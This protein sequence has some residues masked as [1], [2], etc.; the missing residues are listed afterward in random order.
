MRMKP[1]PGLGLLLV[2]A[3]GAVLFYIFAWSTLSGGPFKDGSAEWWQA[4]LGTM[5]RPNDAGPVTVAACV[6]LTLGA[7]FCIHGVW[8]IVRGDGGSMDTTPDQ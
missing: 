4:V 8:S 7:W 1:R 5:F 2:L 6:G 3:S